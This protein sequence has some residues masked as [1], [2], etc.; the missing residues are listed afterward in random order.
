MT[1]K[2][3]EF[4][5]LRAYELAE[6]GRGNTAPNPLVGCVIVYQGRII[7]EGWHKKFGE[8]HAE[9][10]AIRSVANP[11][12]LPE[13][14]LYV[15]LEPC[16]HFGKTPPCA[17]L[18]VEKKIKRVVIGH[19]DTHP[20]VAGKGAEKLRKAGIEVCENVL[21]RLF[22]EQND[23]FFYGIQAEKPCVILK[24]AETAD[25]FIA[26]EN[27]SSKWISGLWSR[28]L[29]H[30]FRGEI[31]AIMV[32]TETALRDNPRLDV[33]LWAGKN[34]VRLLIDRYLR[35]PNDL[36]VFQDGGKTIC[37]NLFKNDIS[38]D[39]NIEWVQISGKDFLP[40]MLKDL[41]KRGI[42]SILVEGGAQIIQF[43]LQNNV[44]NEII[45]FQ[46]PAY[47]GKGIEAP[48]F[49][50]RLKSSD[51]IGNDLMSVFVNENCEKLH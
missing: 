34:P 23:A 40:E 6:N 22:E 12:L 18:I 41:Y 37:Y 29:V 10:N 39:K 44:W 51:K 27:Y 14:T 1:T 20:F 49:Q 16:A 30:K 17:D 25:G 21:E 24:W 5:M 4:F 15:S 7:G 31:P 8:A 9:V 36:N 28:A 26:R 32:G 47:F 3:D 19:C 43:F 48:R 45:R 42:Q 2:E 35:L 11:A 46:S 13:S 33:R 38:P 50:G